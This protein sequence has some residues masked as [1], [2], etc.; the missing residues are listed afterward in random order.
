MCNSKQKE[1]QSSKNKLAKH[2]FTGP[3]RKFS[4]PHT[5]PMNVL[6]DNNA[7]TGV[8]S[9]EV[10]DML[11]VDSSEPSPPFTVTVNMCGKPLCMKMDTR[12]TVSA[13][14]KKLFYE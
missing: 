10:F 5:L 8:T 12:A 13:L 3:G 14:S 7:D 11:Q 2:R 4:P 6:D 1:T 9:S